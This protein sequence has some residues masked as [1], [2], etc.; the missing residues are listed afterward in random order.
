MENWIAYQ[1]K[2]FVTPAFPGYTSGHSVFSRA[3]AEVLTSLTGSKFVPGGLGSYTSVAQTP[4]GLLNEHG[5]SQP[6]TL[7]WATYYDAAD[8]AGLSRIFGGIHPPI[9]NVGGRRVGEVTGQGVWEAARKYFDGSI[10]NSPINMTLK[11][12]NS[13]QGEVRYNTLR[14]M[15]YRLQATTNLN[16]PMIDVPGTSPV[17][18]LDTSLAITNNLTSTNIFYRAVRTLTP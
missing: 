7:Q 9:D 13:T 1:K 8:Q 6:L 17:L 15:Y 2:T 12:L 18:A 11:K 10:T 3:A 4:T 14:G 5:P 16:Q